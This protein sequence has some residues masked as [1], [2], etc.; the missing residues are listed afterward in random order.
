MLEILILNLIKFYQKFVS[1]GFGRTCRFYPSCSQYF[2]LAIE[3][4]GLFVGLF[5]GMKRVLR[6]HPWNRGGLDLP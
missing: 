4:H 2:Y 5:L 1:Q 6:C 3:K